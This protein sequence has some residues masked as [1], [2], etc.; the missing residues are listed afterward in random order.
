M[1]VYVAGRQQ[2]KTNAVV[3]WFLEQPGERGVIVANREM[4]NHFLHRLYQISGFTRSQFRRYEDNIIPVDKLYSRS[5]L[6]LRFREVAI[7]DAE[8]VIKTL[9]GAP[10]E[11]MALNG[12]LLDFRYTRK[13]EQTDYVDG[14]VIPDYDT[15]YSVGYNSDGKGSSRAIGPSFYA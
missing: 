7:D 12:T 10:I 6:R 1:I 4:R 14:E 5:E 8:N 15:D 13:E 3:R 11:F 2:G 9:L